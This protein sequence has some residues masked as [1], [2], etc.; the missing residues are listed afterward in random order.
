[1]KYSGK[2][3]LKDDEL[4]TRGSM[5]VMYSDPLQKRKNTAFKK[6][7]NAA[8]AGTNTG[9]RYLSAKLKRKKRI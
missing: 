5:A 8:G 1:M 3:K 7:K 9:K 2:K 6:A 4:T